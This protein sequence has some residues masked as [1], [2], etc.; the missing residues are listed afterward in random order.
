[1]K[2]WETYKP[3]AKQEIFHAIEPWPITLADGRK[4]D[5]LVKL[6]AGGLGAGKSTACEQEQAMVCLRTPGGKSIAVRQS[7]ERSDSSLIEDYRKILAGH[8]RWVPSKHWFQFDNGHLL[9]VM[10]SDK[11]DRYGSVEIVSFYM[12]EAQE[13]KYQIFDALEQRLR[14]P[15]G[16][17]DGMSFYRGYLCARGVKKDHW[18]YKEI[19]ERGWDASTPKDKRYRVEAPQR[20]YVKGQTIDNTM[21][22]APGYRERLLL[23]HE[24]DRRWQLMFLEGEF[25]FDLEGRPVFE[26]FDVEEHVAEVEPDRSLPIFRGIDF[27]YR[28][29]AVVWCQLMREGRFVVLHELCPQEVSRY[30][31]VKMVESEQQAHFPDYGPMHYRD[32]GD[33]AGENENSAGVTDIEYWES[34]FQTG[35]EFRKARIKDGLEVM[36]NLMNRQGRYQGKRTPM[37]LVNKSCE[38]LITALSGGYYY[39]FDKLNDEPVKGNG[40]DD[41]V[42]AV[43]YVCQLVAEEAPSGLTYGNSGR[44]SGSYASY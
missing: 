23:G 25:G 15:A 42:D 11:F 18:I 5:A 40:Y 41:V 35:V 17:I 21:Y 38:K 27:G 1:M 34:H 7:M 37:F 28:R 44:A 33:I 10:P 6:F 16:V 4:A 24:K 13:M 14:H 31:L 9:M 29:P 3:N 39:D 26:E 19:V 43:R 12:Q 20:V 2:V 32:F 22:L 30:D 8:A 36:R